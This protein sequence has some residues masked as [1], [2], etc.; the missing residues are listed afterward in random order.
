MIVFVSLLDPGEIGRVA[1]FIG[2]Q[3]QISKTGERG[4]N[5]ALFGLSLYHCGGVLSTENGAV[6]GPRSYP[7]FRRKEA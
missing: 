5:K 6:D 1:F 2:Y 3:R 7:H 4:V